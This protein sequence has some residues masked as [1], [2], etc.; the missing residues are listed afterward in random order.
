MAKLTRFDNI[1]QAFVSYARMKVKS[2]YFSSLNMIF[3]LR[4]PKGEH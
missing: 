4:L 3:V 1:F 2:D